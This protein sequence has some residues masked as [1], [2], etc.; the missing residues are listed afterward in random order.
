LKR[1]EKFYGLSFLTQPSRVATKSRN[2]RKIR[3]FYIQL[4]TVK[5]KK[6]FS[7]KSEKIMEI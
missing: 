1:L 7:E 6:N 2:L 4:G 5:E 3:E